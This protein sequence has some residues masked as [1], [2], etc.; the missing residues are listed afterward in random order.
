MLRPTALFCSAALLLA[1]CL[2]EPPS[3]SRMVRERILSHYP[4]ATITDRDE[5]L[6]V[7]LD[8][9]TH[10]VELAPIA[11][12]CNRGINDCERVLTEM[13]LSLD[14]DAPGN[15]GQDAR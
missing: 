13:L 6:E 15:P 10:R 1:A 8:G 2:S 4:A 7:S 9:K 5:N 3:W 12:Q 11:L 14:K